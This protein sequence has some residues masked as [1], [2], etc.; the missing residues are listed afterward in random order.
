MKKKQYVVV[1]IGLI[2]NHLIV[3]FAFKNYRHE[4]KTKKM[5]KKKT[6]NNL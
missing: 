6:P 4:G 3:L 2:A 5:K 1:N